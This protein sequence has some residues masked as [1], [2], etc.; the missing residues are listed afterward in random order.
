[1]IVNDDQLSL[2]IGKDGQNARLAS[3]L[4]GWKI[5][6][7]S[8]TESKQKRKNELYQRL[9]VKNLTNIPKRKLNKLSKIYENVLLLFEASDEEILSIKGLKEED[10]KIIRKSIDDICEISDVQQHLQ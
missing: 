3:K 6:I 9:E 2:A 7:Y 8:I 4:T 1:M 10:I 5:D